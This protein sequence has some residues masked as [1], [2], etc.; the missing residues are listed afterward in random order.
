MARDRIALRGLKFFAYHGVLREEK[1]LGQT[2]IVDID[3]YAD[4][5]KAGQSDQVE[6]TINYAEVYARIKTIVKMEKYH[7]I[8]RLAE[9]IAEEVL[10]EFP[11]EGVRVV[12]HK[13]QAPIPGIFDE[14][15]VEIYREKNR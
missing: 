1:I 10:G 6:D 9:R 11:C 3:L 12:I 14:A 4:L 15:F 7:L 8:E 5:S 2:F 13:P